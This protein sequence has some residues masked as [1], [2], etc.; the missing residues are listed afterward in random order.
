MQW[1]AGKNKY[2]VVPL[3]EDGKPEFAYSDD[4]KYAICRTMTDTGFVHHAWLRKF[5]SR[6]G[7][8]LPEMIDGGLT[9]SQAVLVCEEHA[10]G[11][12]P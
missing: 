12:N 5:N 3:L 10:R 6:G 7:W 8:E 11:I 4:G 9:S 1:A 2:G